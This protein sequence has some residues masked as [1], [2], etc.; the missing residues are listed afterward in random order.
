M[1]AEHQSVD[2]NDDEPSATEVSTSVE[3]TIDE[4][5]RLAELPTR[6]LREY[7]R[8]GLLPAPRRRGRIGVYDDEHLRRLRLIARLQQRG[9]SLA[10]IG[11]L[12]AA[13]HAGDSLDTIL[14]DPG[15]DEAAQSF[16]RNGLLEHAPWLRD[17]DLLGDATAAG[18]VTATDGRWFVRAPSLLQLLGDAIDAG[19]PP[20]AA[21]D[22]ARAMRTGAATQAR[23]LSDVFVEHLWGH[24][25]PGELDRLGRRSRVLAARSAA[26]LLVDELARALLAATD[27][28]PLSDFVDRMR[29]RVD[30]EPPEDR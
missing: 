28:E 27:G 3:W 5:A 1:S 19:A 10:G 22:V 14:D 18:L 23:A 25:D 30:A 2:P 11:D 29:L 4:L 13:W 20:S 6:T 17:G 9:Y 12:L 16:T 21:I 26:A 8:L 15:L 24:T 7:R